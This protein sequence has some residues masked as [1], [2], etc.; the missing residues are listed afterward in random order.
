LI[1]KVNDDIKDKEIGLNEVSLRNWN[2]NFFWIQREFEE[3][4]DSEQFTNQQKIINQSI[5]NDFND[6]L[7]NLERECLPD[8]GFNFD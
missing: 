7:F 3:I 5:D 8:L 2:K 4:S 1:F 6:V